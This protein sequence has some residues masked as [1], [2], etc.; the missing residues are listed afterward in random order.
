METVLE[1]EREKNPCIKYFSHG[2]CNFGELCRSSHRTSAQ[3][4]QLE[5]L[6]RLSYYFLLILK[7][8]VI[9]IFNKE[10]HKKVKLAEEIRKNS[11][12]KKKLQV[13]NSLSDFL[14]YQEE[15]II[16]NFFPKYFIP[17]KIKILNMAFLPPSLEPPSFKDFINYDT[18]SWSHDPG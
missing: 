6:Y 12:P 3:K 16:E 11:A 10:C 8:N 15:K 9:L 17:K 7:M 2:Y 4:Q 1:E 13:K 5:D 14:E 18:N